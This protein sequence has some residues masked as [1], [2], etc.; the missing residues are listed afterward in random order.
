MTELAPSWA[1]RLRRWGSAFFRWW[2]TGLQALLPGAVSR[3]LGTS[4]QRLL[5][6]LDGDAVALTRVVQRRCQVV[7]RHAELRVAPIGEHFSIDRQGLL[8]DRH[9]L[10]RPAESQK[11]QRLVLKRGRERHGIVVTTPDLDAAI[12]GAERVL[13]PFLGIE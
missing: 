4:G 8:G 1:Y 2:I 10:G 11:Q 5:L 3:A 12:P 9:G 7:D 13:V 6:T